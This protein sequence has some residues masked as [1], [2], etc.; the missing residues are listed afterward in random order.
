MASSSRLKPGEKGDIDATVDITGKRGKI[1]KTI[2]VY[3]NDP[4]TPVTVLSL[5]MDVIDTIHIGAF[6][7]RE[8]FS[9]KCK[10][11]HVDRGRGKKGIALFIADCMMCHKQGKSASSSVKMG[12]KPKAYIRDAI[13]NGVA[14]TTM[15]GFFTKNGGPLTEEEIESLVNVIK[16]Q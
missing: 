2:K 4:A 9:E 12:R 16:P 7:A 1:A 6:E 13:R 3:T 11:C 10:G 5:K 8:I 14:Q 15:P